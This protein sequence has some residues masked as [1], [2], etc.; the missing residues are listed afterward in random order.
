MHHYGGGYA[1][2]KPF[3]DTW[4]PA[5]KKLNESKKHFIIGYPEL[6]YGGLTPLKH[7]FLADKSIYPNYENQLYS[8]ELV[9]KD[10]TKHTPL[11]IGTCSF[12]C[13]PYTPLTKAWYE[14]L[15]KRMDTAYDLLVD[16]NEKNKGDIIYNEEEYP[17]KGYPIPYFHL[18]GQIIHP[19]MLKYHQHILQYKKLIPVLKDY[20]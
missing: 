20:R 5:F 16:F 13:K 1:D 12:I 18:L 7:N 10:L 11:L 14:E 17:D 15:H 19:L 4:E 6:L 8:E 9:F 3:T 2:V